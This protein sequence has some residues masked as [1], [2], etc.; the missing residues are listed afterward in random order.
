MT[1]LTEKEICP[2]TICYHNASSYTIADSTVDCV[3]TLDVEMQE[4]KI[5]IPSY[6]KDY[7]ENKI[8]VELC[9]SLYREINMGEYTIFFGLGTGLLCI[10]AILIFN[11]RY[12][13]KI[14]INEI[15]DGMTINIENFRV[16]IEFE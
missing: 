9:K 3:K 13:K 15:Y 10:Q 11:N 7:I 12:V 1:Q 6:W 5:I 16:T 8:G 14:R 4:V 2:G